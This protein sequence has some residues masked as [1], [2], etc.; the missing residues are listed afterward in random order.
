MLDRRGAQLQMVSSDGKREDAGDTPWRQAQ[1]LILSYDWL[2]RN[3]GRFFADDPGYDMVIFDE[4]HHA[5]YLEVNNLQRRR[6]NSYLAMLKKISE[7]TLGLMLLTATPMQI[8]PSELWALL[9]TLNAGE[10]WN[11][12][13]FRRFYDVNAPHTLEEW[14]AARQVYLQNDGHESN[15]RI[16][17]LARISVAEARGTPQIHSDA[18]QQ[19]RC[20]ET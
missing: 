8:D 16:A 4:A 13:D 6:D 5:R 14:N 3:A 17:E 11:E 9:Q 12:A 20:P 10:G 2:R 1:H 15:E 7:K 19:C 18:R